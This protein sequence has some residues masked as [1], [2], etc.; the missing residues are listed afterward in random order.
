MSV[1]SSELR[2][3]ILFTALILLIYR[4]GTFVPIPG[5][6]VEVLK[7]F[8][9][10]EGANIFGMI[11]LFSGG[12]LERM[13]I[14][15]LNIMPYITASIIMQLLTSM[16]KGLEALKKEGEYGRAKL[17]QYTRYLTIV[18]AFFQ[19][20]GVY[21]A[22]ANPEHNA[23]ITDSKIFMWTTCVSLVGGTVMLM[24]FGER[25]TNSGIGNGISLIIFVGI[26]SSLP[27]SMVQIFDLS[28]TGVYSW[29]TILF[30]F[31]AFVLFL[32]LV[33]FIEKTHKRIKIQYPNA[34]MMKASGMADS[35]FLP[36]KINISGVIPPIFASSILMFPAAIVQF[37]GTDGDFFVS[38]LRRGGALYLLLFAA[39]ITFFSYFYSSIIFNTEEVSNNLKK[40]NCFIL[41]IRPG[42]ATSG[43]LDKIV[44][45]LTLLGAVY[46]SFV[47]I[48]PEILVTNYSIPL[49]LGGTGILI[50]V[51]VVMDLV[52][53]IQSHL[54]ASRYG[55]SGGTPRRR[56]IRVRG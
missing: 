50:M 47:C 48:V 16:Y 29:F 18:L 40:S 6:N 25:I 52:N 20:L 46:L 22:L 4:F 11:N 27:A 2:Q 24:W 21:Y 14:F 9:A 44:S 23:F 54:F 45:R 8:F 41:G 38:I 55:T 7:K 37:T 12:A 15:A 19:S 1:P 42:S 43:Y 26:V 13:S 17:N 32:M 10:S 36:L 3:R 33:C 31:A 49:Q 30:F 39:L 51:N 56:K 28:K 35:S 53:Q 34:A 5:I